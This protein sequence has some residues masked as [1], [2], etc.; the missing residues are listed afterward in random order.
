MLASCKNMEIFTKEITKYEKDTV[1]S[2]ET[3][4]KNIDS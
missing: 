2:V 4:V 1:G 3:H